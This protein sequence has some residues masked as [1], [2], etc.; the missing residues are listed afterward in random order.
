MST[1]PTEP[2]A[3]ERITELIYQTGH[4]TPGA[5]KAAL[6]I[7]ETN[8]VVEKA[9]LPK[10]DYEEGYLVIGRR[11]F[12]ANISVDDRRRHAY[13]LLAIAE[14]IEAGQ[15]A[16]KVAAEKLTKRRDELAREFD[17]TSDPG[18]ASFFSASYSTRRAIDRII[19]MESRA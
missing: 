4:G 8:I 9:S 13:Q 17:D 12:V 3:L 5:K 18:L 14:H 16:E 11:H 6:K 7:L 2:S 10:I 19:S 1:E 15:S